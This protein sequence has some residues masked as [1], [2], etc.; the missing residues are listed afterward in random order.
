VLAFLL[1]IGDLAESGTIDL[2]RRT[3]ERRILMAN[4]QRALPDAAYAF[5][6]LYGGVENALLQDRLL[7]GTC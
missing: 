7:Q 3:I 2:I 6:D 5:T 4:E 1:L